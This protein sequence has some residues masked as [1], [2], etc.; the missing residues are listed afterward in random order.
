[1]RKSS[2]KPAARR[3]NIQRFTISADGT[4]L[5]AAQA[6]LNGMSATKVKSLLRHTQLAVNGT[7]STQFDLPVKRGDV[8][9]VN[10]GRSFDVFSHPRV[11]IVYEDRDIIVVDKASGILSSNSRGGE[12]SVLDVLR[13][14]VQS[15]SEHGRV[16]VVHR[17]DRDT[18]GL[19][20]LTRS[21]AAREE[22]LRNWTEMVPERRF[23][24]V[25]EGRVKADEGKVRTFL[26]DDEQGYEVISTSKP[27]EGAKPAVTRYTVIERGERNTLVELEM[28][29][30]RKNQMRV[31][32]RDLGCPVSGDLKY[33]GH[34]NP[35]RRM[36]LHATSLKI[37]HPKTG[38]LLNLASPIPEEFY[39][40]L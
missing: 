21:A 29:T 37:I 5:S 2:H 17:L 20:V 1:M 11:K 18:S 7:P 36:A 40:I 19:M 6:A 14:Y 22:L 28:K 12:E 35:I 23:A 9:E 4:L 24:A 38:K 25:V 26:R 15:Q 10:F 33:G 3:D 27:E 30:A 31:H 8:L 39:Q 16:L 32:M 34:R 13:R